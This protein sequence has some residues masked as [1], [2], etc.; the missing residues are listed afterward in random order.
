MRIC[1]SYEFYFQGEEP[2]F[3]NVTHTVFQNCKI[4]YFHSDELSHDTDT[5]RELHERVKSEGW[6][7]EYMDNLCESTVCCYTYTKTLES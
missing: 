2:F 1:I 3:Y 4:V 6:A 7:C 5:F